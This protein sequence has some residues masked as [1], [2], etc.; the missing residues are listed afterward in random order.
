ME[1]PISKMP[2]G[3]KW[4]TKKP[5]AIK[6]IQLEYPFKVK[7]LEG[8]FHAKAGDYLIEGIRGELYSCEEEIFK[9]SYE[10]L[11]YPTQG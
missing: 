7:T 8:V 4:Y 3:F 10:Q 2:K 11:L 9:E 1:K 5:I 6:A